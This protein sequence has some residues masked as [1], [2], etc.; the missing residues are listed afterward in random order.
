MFLAGYRT[1]TVMAVPWRRKIM[2][3][4]NFFKGQNGMPAIKIS[5][6]KTFQAAY[7]A[8]EGFN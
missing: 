4:Q 1:D 5:L 7:G 3:L 6:I 2:L 8:K